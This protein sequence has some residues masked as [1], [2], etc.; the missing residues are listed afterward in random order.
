MSFNF[1]VQPLSVTPP[2]DWEHIRIGRLLVSQF[3]S[4]KVAERL[5]ESSPLIY[6]QQCVLI[7]LNFFFSKN[8]TSLAAVRISNDLHGRSNLS[9]H[10]STHLLDV[11]KDM[12]H[13]INEHLR[14][15]VQNHVVQRSGDLLLRGENPYTHIRTTSL[16]RNCGYV[17]HFPIEC[18]F[19]NCVHCGEP[20]PQHLSANC[21][22]HPD[23][24]YQQQDTLEVN[25]PSLSTFSSTL[26]PEQTQESSEVDGPTRITDGQTNESPSSSSPS[27][28]LFESA[29]SGSD[30]ENRNN[31]QPETLHRASSHPPQRR[32]VTISRIAIV[33]RR[34]SLRYRPYLPNSTDSEPQE[35]S[36]EGI[37]PSEGDN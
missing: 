16:C 28:T 14:V 32:R 17:G 27:P 9:A 7:L 22:A 8:R 30:Q 18:S 31:L 26:R 5:K 29:V 34:R 6:Q 35:S 3:L 19:W 21:P 2:L 11:E 12:M 33:A 10:L 1:T 25:L 23:R 20:A 37:V 36:E 4:T 15:M 24:N 13:H